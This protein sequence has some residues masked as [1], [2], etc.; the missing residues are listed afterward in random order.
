MFKVTMKQAAALVASRKPFKA[1][2]A[3]AE[4]SRHY[5]VYSY[6]YHWPLLAYINGRWYENS[7]KASVTTS[8]HLTLLRPDAETIPVS[9]QDITALF[10]NTQW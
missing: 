6:G 5:V 10:E 2:S 7:D 1:N 4:N 8:K 3:F 9:L